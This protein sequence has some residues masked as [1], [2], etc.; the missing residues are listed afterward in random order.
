MK[1]VFPIK[2][3]GGDM[4]SF[5]AEHVV[6]INCFKNK[7][8]HLEIYNL[9]YHMAMFFLCIRVSSHVLSYQL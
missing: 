2:N 8:P 4:M 9:R 7:N 5:A 3:S 6:A 1:V